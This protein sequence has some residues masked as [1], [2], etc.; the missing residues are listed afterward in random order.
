LLRYVGHWPVLGFGFWVARERT[1][2]RFVGEVGFAEQKRGLDEAGAG[3]ELGYALAPWCHGQGFATEAARAV[4][5]WGDEHIPMKR[6]WC[7]INPEASASIQVA[8]KCGYRECAR[9]TLRDAPVVLFER[10]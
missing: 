9:A 5:A 8:E 4:V 1:S 2:G 6:T 3:P 10:G 7:L